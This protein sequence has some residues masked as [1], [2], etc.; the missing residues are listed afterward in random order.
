MW[1]VN[2]YILW[3]YTFDFSDLQNKRS[4]RYSDTVSHQKESVKAGPDVGY[5]LQ[6]PPADPLKRTPPGKRPNWPQTEL[7]GCLKSD[8]GAYKKGKY[9]TELKASQAIGGVVYEI[10]LC[11]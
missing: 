11:G 7:Y 1:H 5:I 3:K 9:K 4:A 10:W 8:R 6:M 2:V